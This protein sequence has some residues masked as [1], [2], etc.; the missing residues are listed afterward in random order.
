MAPA[1]LV[2]LVG[3]S[4]VGKT[5]LLRMIGGIDTRFEGRVTIDGIDAADAPPAGFVLQDARLLPWLTVREN[6]RAVAPT[7]T[8]DAI[9]RLL[10]RVGLGGTERRFPHQL[11]GGMQRR[12]A[13]ARAFS[14][15]PRLLAAR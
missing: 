7:M 8:E 9:A 6:I 5:T 12:V 11:S 3:P 13:I 1:T 10:E 14:F 2:A 4:G 15:N